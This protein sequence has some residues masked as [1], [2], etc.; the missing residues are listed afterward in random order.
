MTVELLYG[1]ISLVVGGI[2]VAVGAVATVKIYKDRVQSMEENIKL[3]VDGPTFMVC[4]AE[5][6]KRYEAI[7]EKLS[8][9]CDNVKQIMFFLM[10]GKFPEKEE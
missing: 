6:E 8:D 4:R 10:N 2:G 3:K 5:S 1:L 7:N 9:V